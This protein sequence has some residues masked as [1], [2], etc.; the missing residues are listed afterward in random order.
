LFSSRSHQR[1]PELGERQRSAVQSAGGH[2][3]AAVQ[4]RSGE[5]QSLFRQ[6]VQGPRGV[7]QVRAENEAAGHG[8]Q[9]ARGHRRRK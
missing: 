5:R 9:S 8:L 1:G 7:L 3:P 2:C 4:L 6:V